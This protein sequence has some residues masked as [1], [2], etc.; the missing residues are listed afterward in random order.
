VD[1]LLFWERLAVAATR[2]CRTKLRVTTPTIVCVSANPALDRRLRVGALAVGEVNRAYSAEALPGGKAAH[3]AMAA[4]ALRAKAV[5]V[6]FL[7]GAIGEQCAGAMRQIGIEVIPVQTRASTRVN[8]EVIEE[9]GRITEVLEPGQPPSEDERKKMLQ[10]CAQGF[11]DA[12]A[13]ALVVISGSLPTGTPGDFYAALI[14][15]ARSEGSI[16]FLDTSG[17]ALRSSLGAKPDL[18]KPNRTEAESLLGRPVGDFLSA[19]GAARDV[20]AAGAE[21]AMITLG[22]QG[23][24]WL[25]AR[26][27][28]AWIARPPRLQAISTVGCGDVTLGGF[29][30]ATLQGMTGGDALRFAAA[31]GA[32]NCLAKLEGQIS[33]QD[34]E[35]LIPR[36]EIER[37]RPW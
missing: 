33:R 12:W 35:S 3:V 18:V 13:G 7:G 2:L 22:A 31:C 29:A 19:A 21:S 34:V 6:G 27:G 25:E 5:W 10:M 26:N 11:H 1:L 8:L 32:A 16:V 28:P 17:D 36:V 9:S 37:L 23:M 15:S 4:H 14:N 20:I 30:Y 24:L